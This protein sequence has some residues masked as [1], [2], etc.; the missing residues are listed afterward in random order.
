AKPV[1]VRSPAIK[2]VPTPTVA[3]KPVAVRSPAIKPAP[4]PTVAAKP[5]AV[6]SPAIKPAPKPTIAVKPVAV[7]S[8][9]PKPTAASGPTE[10]RSQ[11]VRAMPYP[12]PTPKKGDRES[13]PSTPQPPETPENQHSSG[14]LA[15][16][17]L[18]SIRSGDKD[19]PEQLAVPEQNQRQ[20][21][22]V[23]NPL[24]L[25]LNQSSAVILQVLVEIDDRGK[26]TAIKEVNVVEDSRS[27]QSTAKTTDYLGLAKQ[28]LKDWEFHPAYSGGQPVYS[29]LWLRLTVKAL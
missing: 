3:A 6:R 20:F 29:E 15:T 16:F 18:G 4:K 25:G 7:R 9:T 26:L 14:V 8:P 19:I 17:D 28:L 12:T 13:L 11:P 21:P 1:A 27:P 22:S 23:L 2:P 5:V 24:Q 10:K